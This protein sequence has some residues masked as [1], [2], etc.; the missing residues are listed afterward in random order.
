MKLACH[1]ATTLMISIAACT[2]AENPPTKPAGLKP[3][4]TIM[5]V[6]PAG[7][8]VRARVERAVQRLEALGYRVIVAETLFRQRGYLAGTDR[9]RADELMAAFNNPDVKAIF[10][11]RGG[12]GTTRMLDLLDFDE[13]DANPKVLLGFSDI[14]GLH[15]A[16][17]KKCNF[18]TFHTPLAQGLGSTD[19]LSEFSAKSFWRCLLASENSGITGF[20][21]TTPDGA[22]LQSLRGGTARGRLIGGNFSLIAATMGTPYEIQT[23]GRVL[24]LEDVNEAPYR[25]D[26]M[27][28]QLK[29]AG[30]LEK[31]AAVILGQFTKADL[32][33]GDA[34][35]TVD[36]IFADYFAAAPYPVVKNFPAGHVENNATLAIGAMYEVDG[37]APRVRL[38]ENPVRE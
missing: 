35:L 2:H 24:F 21:Y 38:L 25:I 37:D 26:R 23:E 11:C 10:P 27:L 3:G 31:P 1:L 4:D 22:P 7:T 33:E 17:A 8:L 34:S 32:D 30:K 9:E 18:V 12:Y 20:E 15:L 13:I 6:A 28:S 14:T 19:G 16:L 5:F 36:E 29:L